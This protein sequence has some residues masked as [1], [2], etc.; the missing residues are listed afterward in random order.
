MLLVAWDHYHDRNYD[1]SWQVC[2]SSSSCHTGSQQ[3]LSSKRKAS[4]TDVGLIA[5]RVASLCLQLPPLPAP[6]RCLPIMSES[7]QETLSLVDAPHACPTWLAHH[8][9]ITRHTL[10]SRAL[11]WHSCLTAIRNAC[12]STLRH[13]HVIRASSQN[14][15]DT[16]V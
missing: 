6:M 16:N 8:N 2:L 15:I 13:T 5:P 1:S 7:Q 14:I 12:H 4:V 11:M 10:P 9:I 3:F